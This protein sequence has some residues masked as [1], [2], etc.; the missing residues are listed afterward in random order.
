MST[1]LLKEIADEIAP[2]ITILFQA[3][4]DQGTTPSSWKKASVL[5]LFKK[6]NRSSAFNYRPISV[7]SILCKLCEHIVH[8]SIFDHLT[9]YKLLT[10]AQH[11]FRK[12]R[13]CETQLIQTIHDLAKGINSLPPTA[14]HLVK[15]ALT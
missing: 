6:G 5:P 10:D 15:Q 12:R 1:R 7:T 9:E 4:L 8:T 11:G 3:S 14:H 13:S 2:A